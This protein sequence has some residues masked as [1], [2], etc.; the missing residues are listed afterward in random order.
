[1]CS[2]T[3]LIGPPPVTRFGLVDAVFVGVVAAVDLHVA[4]FFL[5]VGAGHLQARHAVDDVDGETETVDLVFDGQFQRRV[6][7]AL[8]LVAAYVQIPVV[9]AA[10]GEAVDQPGIAVEVKNDR[11]VEGKQAVEVAV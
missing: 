4:Q 5:H 9:G 2:D 11:L 3:L 10:V 1:M 6:D 7:I 8:F